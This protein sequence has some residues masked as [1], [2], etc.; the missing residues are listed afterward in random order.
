MKLNKT[1][2]ASLIVSS[3]HNFFPECYYP[4]EIVTENEGN[5]KISLFHAL[6]LSKAI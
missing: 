2:I 6:C 3:E 4:D 5:V 1:R